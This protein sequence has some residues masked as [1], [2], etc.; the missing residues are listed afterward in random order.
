MSINDAFLIGPPNAFHFMSTAMSQ[1]RKSQVML[2]SLRNLVFVCA[3]ILIVGCASPHRPSMAAGP[4]VSFVMTI[5]APLPHLADAEKVELKAP[6]PVTP[7]PQDAKL[8]ADSQPPEASQA[9]QL[10][11]GILQVFKSFTGH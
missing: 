4:K 7:K 1:M 10:A 2:R 8:V 11:D 5:Q 6:A 3:P 9:G